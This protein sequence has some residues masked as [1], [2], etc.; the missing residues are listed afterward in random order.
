MRR[1]RNIAK[2]YEVITDEGTLLK[3]IIISESTSPSLIQTLKQQFN[4]PNELILFDEE[5]KRVEVAGWILE[6][7]AVE[8]VKQGFECYLVEEYPTADRLEVER[9]PLT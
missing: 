9:I 7:R 2:P 3:G 1:A 4:I 5:K 6:E 8:L